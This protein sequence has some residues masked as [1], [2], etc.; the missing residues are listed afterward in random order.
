M[1]TTNHR[2]GVR[3]FY[4]IILIPTHIPLVSFPKVWEVWPVDAIIYRHMW[5]RWYHTY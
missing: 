4:P 5:D 3:L 2:V 1:P